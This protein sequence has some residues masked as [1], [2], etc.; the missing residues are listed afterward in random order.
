MVYSTHPQ[1]RKKI[2][3][4]IFSYSLWENRLP[5]LREQYQK[6][7]PFPHVVIDEFLQLDTAEMALREFPDLDS[8]DW[9]HYLHAN[10][11]KFGKTNL[12]AFPPKLKA[13]VEELNSPN[14]VQFLSKLTGIER[15]FADESLEGG[16]LHQ[17]AP[18]GFLNTH[19]DFT[20]HPHHRN[21]QRQINILIYL[22]QNWKDEYGG[23]L[24]L[25]D[26]KMSRCIHKIAPI[27]NRSV[28]FN[29]TKDAFHGHP[30]PLKCPSGNTRKS[31]ALYY[32]TEEKKSILIRSTEYRA[33]PGDGLKGLC[34][35]LDKWALRIYDQIKRWTGIDDRFASNLLK[36]LN[37]KRK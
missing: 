34:I 29:T 14:F 22:N 32:F 11:Q 31:I 7:E 28:I 30:E 25:W 15:L 6:A 21:W 20:V 33:R 37:R 16:G 36:F 10:E 35:F 8:E 24:E 17:T 18:G 1:T 27:F 9:I 4:E 12:T 3:G 19:A 5:S 2:E 26:Q 23:H 13:V